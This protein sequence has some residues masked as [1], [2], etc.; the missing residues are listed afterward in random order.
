M[1]HSTGCSTAN[2][3]AVAAAGGDLC[4]F[5]REQCTEVHHIPFSTLYYCELNQNLFIMIIIVVAFMLLAFNI[6]ETT[7]DTYLAPGLECIK[8]RLNLSEAVAGVTLFAL[9]NGALE[10]IA[11]LVAGASGSAGVSIAIGGLFGACFFT[12]TIIL[13]RCMQGGGSIQVDEV[14]MKRDATFLVI[15]VAYFIILTAIDN[16]TWYMAFG[17][18][19]IYILFIVYVVF[20]VKSEEVKNV[21][22]GDGLA[23]V[24]AYLLGKGG[25]GEVADPQKSGVDE[26]MSVWDQHVTPYMLKRISKG[27]EYALGSRGSRRDPKNVIMSL[28][29]PKHW[30]MMGKKDVLSIISRG[31]KRASKHIPMSMMSPSRKISKAMHKPVI[32]DIQEAFERVEK[33]EGN[34]KE[35]VDHDHGHGHGHGDTKFGEFM[36][37]VNVPF[38]FLRDLTMPSL[39]LETWNPIFAFSSPVCSALLLIWQFHLGHTLQENVGVAVIIALVV[40]GL[41]LLLGFTAMKENILK[42]HEAKLSLFAV[43]MSF[44]WL[45]V[46]AGCFVDAL[47]WIALSSGISI[48]YLSLTIFAWQAA[49]D[50]FFI[51]YVISKQGQ[52]RLAIIGLLGGQLFNLYI[53]FGGAMIM[54]AVAAPNGMIT[55]ELWNF[56]EDSAMKASTLLLLFSMI[57]SVVMTLYIGKQ[58]NWLFD[59][60]MMW[61]LTAFYSAFIVI[62]TFITFVF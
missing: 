51:D 54:Q 46:I 6:I 2:L 38:F 1:G 14:S 9:V 18:I 55:L 48:S 41:S 60:K 62:V 27:S 31:S 53:G 22:S 58:K 33:E 10:V 26:P 17:F 57:A 35:E 11:G 21:S 43:V 20:T 4:A 56:A 47:N 15:G 59:Q 7:V 5:V 39:E 8:K 45:H 23:S 28:M 49:L 40:I 3:D 52:G 16:I 42:K 37:L 30:E 24:N 19:V 44:A 12:I 36:R 61:I 32:E 25:D 50:D 13:A 34:L 29:T